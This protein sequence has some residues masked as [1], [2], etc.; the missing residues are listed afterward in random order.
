MTRKD[1]QEP[2]RGD[3]AWR[4]Q[5]Q[6]VADNNEAAYK[7]GREQRATQEA[8]VTERMRADADRERRDLP[9]QPTP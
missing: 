1:E 2:L 9:Q 8:R 4:A 5:K 3:A 7:K 6:R